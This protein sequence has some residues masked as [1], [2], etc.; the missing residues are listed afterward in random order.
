MLYFYLKSLHIIG[1]V[2][3]FAGLFYL[4]RLFVY[5]A[6]AKSRPEVEQQVLQP[7]FLLMMQRLY[8]IITTPAMF[9]TLVGGVGMILVQPAVLQMWL[10]LKL[11]LV[12]LLLL[13]HL[14][15]K[16]IISDLAAGKLSLNA[17]QF[18]WFN[19]LPTLLLVAIVLLAVFKSALNFLQAFIVLIVLMLL[20]VV[21]I[22]AYKR[23]RNKG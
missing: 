6:E 15:C 16:S 3:W 13:Y 22:K 4:A 17:Q 5:Y 9:I 19:E 1:F 7:H 20:I 21:G 8:G 11:G 12:G 14:R 18:R 23:H 2:S 10:Y